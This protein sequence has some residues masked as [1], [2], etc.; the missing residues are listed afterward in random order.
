ML[1]DLI[2]QRIGLAV[3][4]ASIAVFGLFLVVAPAFFP[5]F[6]EWKYFGIGNNIWAGKGITTV[7]GGEFL[8]HGPIWSAVVTLPDALFGGDSHTWGRARSIT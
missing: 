8:L 6:D 3:T 1:P 5:S 7:F 2:E 4:I